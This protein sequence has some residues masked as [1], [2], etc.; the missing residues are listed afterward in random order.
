MASKW[1]KD[2]RRVIERHTTDY[3]VETTTKNHIKVVVRSAGR[4]RKLTVSSSPSCRHALNQF[5]RD[6]KKAL[7]E[8]NE[9]LDLGTMW[10]KD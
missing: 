1:Y 5:E 8:L 6:V 4:S 7:I 2:I 9:G 3:D 10:S